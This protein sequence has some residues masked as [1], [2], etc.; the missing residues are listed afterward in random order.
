VA[1]KTGIEHAIY[2]FETKQ[3][4]DNGRTADHS[5]EARQHIGHQLKNDLLTSAGSSSQSSGG[6]DS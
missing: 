5:T 6:S 1:S 4:R 2:L 3:I